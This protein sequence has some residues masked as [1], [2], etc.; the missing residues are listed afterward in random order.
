MSQ[1]LHELIDK[2]PK[3]ELHLHIEGGAMYPEF[4]LELAEKNKVPL[5][6]EDLDSA[7]EFYKFESLDH[8]IHILRTTVATLCDAEDYCRAVSIIGERAARQNIHYHELMVSPGLRPD[9][10]LQ[11]VFAGMAAGRELNRK[12]FGVETRFVLDIDRTKPA[13]FGL[14]LVETGAAWCERAGIIAVGLDCQE[15]G[16]PPALHKAAYARAAELGFR[17]AG[18]AGEDGPAAYMW[19]GIRECGFE[20]IDH[21]VRAVEDPALVRY[22]AEHRIPLTVCPLSNLQLRVFP[23]MP[24]HT[25]ETL[26]QAG[27]LVT[28][29]SD[30]P[31]MFDCDMVD[32]FKAVVDCFKLDAAAVVELARNG[33]E[34]SFMEPA[35]KATALREFDLAATELLG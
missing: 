10:P 26:R 24:A 33:F 3:T 5:P 8:F 31:P 34:A 7:R 35:E 15:N 2:L 12:R 20:R 22:L 25:I 29:N 18:H 6:F 30:D 21:G 14:N 4:A 27:V 32:D 17:R 23:E 19:E 11:E 28:I 9:V 1:D 16:F 13:D